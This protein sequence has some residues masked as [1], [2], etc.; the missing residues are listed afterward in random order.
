MSIKT[1]IIIGALLGVS[2]AF[3]VQKFLKTYC[4]ENQNG[5]NCSYFYF[6]SSDSNDFQ[7]SNF[8]ISN[9]KEVNFSKCE[10]GGVNENFFS[11]FPEAQRMRFYDCTVNLTSST[12][13]LGKPTHPLKDLE[14]DYSKVYN[15]RNVN[16]FKSLVDLKTIT[17]SNLKSLI[18][19]SYI[20]DS[21]LLE[22]NKK[23]LEINFA[24]S[25]IS[26]LSV[27]AFWKQ[28]DLIK[29]TISETFLSDMESE[30]L[31]FNKKLETFIFESNHIKYIPA[32]MI[33]PKTLMRL[34]FKNNEIIA[35]SEFN[36]VGLK[37]LVDLDLQRNHIEAVSESAFSDLSSLIILNLSENRIYDIS[38]SHFKPLKSLNVLY[39]NS[40]SIKQLPN[41]IF[42]SLSKLKK[43]WA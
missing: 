22:N 35:V 10:T 13:S 19:Q 12:K 3:D 18:T 6:N 31:K 29:L 16:A 38:K 7:N 28:V 8:V 23:L 40:N 27:D 5:L 26:R 42:D 4:Q 24:N 30:W 1:V 41:N 21:T 15:T 43:V 25:S 20:F 2:A 11:K 14:F 32:D 9:A 36:F 34:S 33:L 37:K 17:F 39:I